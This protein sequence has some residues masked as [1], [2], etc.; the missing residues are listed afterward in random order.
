MKYTKTITVDA[1]QFSKEGFEHV[2]NTKHKTF[3]GE[4]VRHNGSEHFIM[5]PKSG[6]SD[7]KVLEDQWIVTEGDTVSIVSDEDFK[8]QYKEVT[9]KKAKPEKVEAPKA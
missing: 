3:L 5:F 4:E 9:E 1:V 7:I 6:S 2:P 8:E